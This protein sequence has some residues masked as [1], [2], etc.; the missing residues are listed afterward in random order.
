MYLQILESGFYDLVSFQ[1]DTPDYLEG[2]RNG[3][4]A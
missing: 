4:V 1:S 2:I 3:L